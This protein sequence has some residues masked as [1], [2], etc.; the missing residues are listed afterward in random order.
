MGDSLYK[1]SIYLMVSSAVMAG[2]GFFFWLICARLFAAEDIGLATTIISVMGL[3]ASISVLGLNTGLVRYL[4][5]SKDKNNKINTCFTIVALTSIIV[6]SIFLLGLGKFSPR[7]VFIKENILM[8]FAFIFFMVVYSMS[9]IIES[10]FVAFRK[11]KFVLVKNTIFSVVKLGLPFVFFSLGIM[12][13]FG[14]FSAYMSASFI[15]F[16]VVLLILIYK[17]NYK[18]RFV[19]YDSVITKIGKFSF[20]LYLAGFVG[21][22][23]S[24]LMPLIITNTL[25]PETTAYYFMAMQIVSLLFVVSSATNNSLFAEGSANVKSLRKN[26]FKSIWIIAILLIPAILLTFLFG[27]FILGAF[28]EEYSTQGLN[29]LKIMT[30]SAILVSVNSVFGSVF[31]VKKRIGGIMVTSIISA[32]SILGLSFLFMKTYGLIGISYAYII[33]QA[34]VTLTYLSMYKFGKKKYK[35]EKNIKKKK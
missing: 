12:G 24:T 22:L 1:N 33:G 9:S 16:G 29:F 19:F 20:V 31:K 17:F 13:A 27:H 8:S 4:P 32:V 34:I 25:N 23:S 6:S 18:P 28:G 35:P 7:L 26:V 30:L 15:G 21:G 5:N 14:I 11:A 2:F 10:V 3:I